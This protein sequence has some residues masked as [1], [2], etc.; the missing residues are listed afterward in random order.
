MNF[1]STFFAIVLISAGVYGIYY[2]VQWDAKFGTVDGRINLANYDGE[3]Y[4]LLRNGGDL[5]SFESLVSIIATKKILKKEIKNKEHHYFNVNGKKTPDILLGLKAFYLSQDTLIKSDT[6]VV[7]T[8]EQL[9]D[10]YR[11]LNP[12][13]VLDEHQQ[14]YFENVR[15]KLGENYGT[16]EIDIN[17]IVKD[18]DNQNSLVNKY[19]ASSEQ[20]LVYSKDSLEL[21]EKAYIISIISTFLAIIATLPVAAKWYKERFRRVKKN[22]S[23]IEEEQLA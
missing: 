4:K 10:D 1:W 12:F 18:L 15:A 16:V 9:L 13:G 17:Q 11:F 19:L 23:E 5:E 7:N 3:L 20:S 6:N 2:W 22:E 14:Y 21:S 8:I